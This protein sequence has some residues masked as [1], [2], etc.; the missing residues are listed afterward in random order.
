[1]E[2]GTPRDSAS[3]LKCRTAISAAGIRV[4]ENHFVA[5]GGCRSERGFAR[6]TIV[7]KQLGEQVEK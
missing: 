6:K 2:V 4:M 1:M 5:A 7:L 3:P